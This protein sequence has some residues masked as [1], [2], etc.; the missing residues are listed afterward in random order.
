MAAKQGR[1]VL[2]YAPKRTKCILLVS[3]MR[4]LT[5]HPKVMEVNCHAGHAGLGLLSLGRRSVGGVAQRAFE[6]CGGHADGVRAS[7]QTI[8]EMRMVFAVAAWDPNVL[9][10]IGQLVPFAQVVGARA[11]RLPR[12]TRTHCHDESTKVNWVLPAMHIG[13][14]VRI[15]ITV[16]FLSITF[17]SVCLSVI[18]PTHAP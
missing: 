9:F 18:I 11:L 4:R 6:P 3:A 10:C 15:V 17:L 13:Q 7:W 16:Q 5:Q 14:C 8:A 2:L 1:N 12:S